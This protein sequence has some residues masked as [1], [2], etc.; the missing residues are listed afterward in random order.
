MPE[1]HCKIR[2]KN[3]K[4]KKKRVIQGKYYQIK[5]KNIHEK[6][7]LKKNCK[8]FL[9]RKYLLEKLRRLKYQSKRITVNINSLAKIYETICTGRIAFITMCQ[10]W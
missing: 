1:L 6:E 9:K 4:G 10:A 5:E 2:R 8:I 3:F 7:N